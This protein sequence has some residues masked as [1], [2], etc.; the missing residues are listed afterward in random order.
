MTK[1]LLAAG[2]AALALATPSVAE[3]GGHGGGDKG[4]KGGGNAAQVD[5]R[6]GG[7]RGGGHGGG[8][9][10]QTEKRGGGHHGK[11]DRDPGRQHRMAE[12][13][14]KAERGDKQRG[15]GRAELRAERGSKDRVRDERIVT[16][17]KDRDEPR[18][19]ESREDRR[20]VRVARQDRDDWR[21]DDGDV[22]VL[23]SEWRD[24]FDD[25]VRIVRRHFDDDYW[26][27]YGWNFES[28]CPP[29]LAK[30]DN[31][32]LPPGQARKLLGHRLP[33]YYD[34]D[35]LPFTYR[36]WYPD[37]DDYFYRAGD[38]YIYRVDRDDG[39]I[40]GLIPLFG[41]G[42]YLVGDPYPDVYDFY[43]VPVQYQP[44]YAD[45][46]LYHYRYGDG[47]I[48]RVSRGSG[49]V[50]GIVA[51]LAGDFGVGRPLPLGYD[52]YNVPLAYRDRYYDTPD[53]WYR[54]NDGYIYQVDPQT[55]LIQAVIS[56]LI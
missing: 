9:A 38:G 13:S 19:V 3:K 10:A 56:A 5:K 7:D 49:L 39:L 12:E 44:W 40:D 51:L 35:Y 11:A 26:R 8:R 52:A 2:A 15:S 30:K 33:D 21:R 14:R 37:D 16:R 46:D 20:E 54:Y 4:G 31:G 1:W 6:G 47:A 25:D 18:R 34:D 36:S 24:D 45:D 29:G 43:N 22:R 27:P 50:D 48:Y 23:R 55:R 28:N 41:D 53:A 32:C 17:G 42:Y